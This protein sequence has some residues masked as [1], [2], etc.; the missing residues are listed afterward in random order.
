[1]TIFCNRL[2]FVNCLK[3]CSRVYAT[4]LYGDN[5]MSLD[6][7]FQSESA[8][9]GSGVCCYNRRHFDVWQ[10]CACTSLVLQPFCFCENWTK[11]MAFAALSIATRNASMDSVVMCLSL[12]TRAR[13]Y[14]YKTIIFITYVLVTDWDASESAYSCIICIYFVTASECKTLYPHLQAHISFEAL[15]TVQPCA[16][17]CSDNRYVARLE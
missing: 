15:F 6:I 17:R 16:R 13:A 14:L 9:T 7:F 8:V 10:A 1:M 3:L 5:C 4:Q 11:I 12:I 2:L